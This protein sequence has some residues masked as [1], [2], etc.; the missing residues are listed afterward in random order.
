MRSVYNNERTHQPLN[1]HYPVISIH[2]QRVHEP[3]TEPA[4]VPQVHARRTLRAHLRL[5]AQLNL[6]A[7]FAGNRG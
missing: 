3:P 2:L 5:Q 1:G 4:L 7:V 6:N